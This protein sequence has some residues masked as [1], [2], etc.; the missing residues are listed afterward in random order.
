[1]AAR[2]TRVGAEHARAPPP[3]SGRPDVPA[4]RCR[5]LARHPDADRPG[6]PADRDPHP[7]RSSGVETRHHS[8]RLGPRRRLGA[9]PRPGDARRRRRRRRLPGRPPPA[10]RRGL[11]ASSARPVRGQPPAVGGVRPRGHRAEGDRPGG[12]RRLPPPR[13]PVRRARTRPGRRAE[14]LGAAERRHRPPHPLVGVAADA[15]R[16]SP[17]PHPGPRRHRRRHP[18][19]AHDGRRRRQAPHAARCG[20]VDVRGGARRTPSA[21]PT[22]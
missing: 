9:R 10:R 3:R 12:L 2:A 21:T 7:R 8:H 6:H 14:A 17:V 1:M 15:H 5:R 20:G 18:R 19:A 22:P 16:P 11:A 13:P 4:A